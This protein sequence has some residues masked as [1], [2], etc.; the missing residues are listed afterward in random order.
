MLMRILFGAALVITVLLAYQ[1]YSQKATISTLSETH[2]DFILGKQNA[3][4]TVVMFF[5]YN[6]KWSRRAHPVLLQLISRNPNV[7]VVL[8]DYP[9]ITSDS[10]M[11]SRVVMGAREKG[12]YMEL[13]NALMGL[14]N[15]INEAVLKDVVTQLGMDF[16]ELKEL[17]ST[18]EVSRIFEENKQA[19]FFL[20]I[21]SA[22]S[23]V[24]EGKVLSGTG[25]S[26]QDFEDALREV[27]RNR[28]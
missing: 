26:M 12:R 28:R 3:P 5:D 15:D 22:P 23:F 4:E 1:K 20:G 24:V 16:D 2:P 19:A 25:F 17:G 6:S 8:K 13:H 9:G 27:K 7:R 21:Q 18:P 14:E 10:E 11:I